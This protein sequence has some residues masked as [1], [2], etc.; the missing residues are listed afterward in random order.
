MQYTENFFSSKNDNNN[1]KDH[2]FNI[3]AQNIDCRYTSTHN[4]CFGSELRK[5]GI[6]LQPH[7]LTFFSIKKW[8]FKGVYISRSC[9]PDVKRRGGVG[10]NDRLHATILT[11][12]VRFLLNKS[13]QIARQTSRFGKTRSHLQG[14]VTKKKVWTKVTGKKSQS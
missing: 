4:L 12:S 3:N 1:K 13:V 6:P 8:G 7:P 9:F 14:F 5:K 10:S 2:I 11:L